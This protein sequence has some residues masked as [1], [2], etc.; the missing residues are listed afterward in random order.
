VLGDVVDAVA[1]G[2]VGA[3]VPGAAMGWD[4]PWPAAVGG[5]YVAGEIGGWTDVE[6]WPEL[7]PGD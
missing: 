4:A 1:L 5:S 6:C 3:L 7:A 2:V